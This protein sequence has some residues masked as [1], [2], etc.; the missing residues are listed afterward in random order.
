[1]PLPPGKPAPLLD[2][3]LLPKE[4]G[5]LF[6]GD[7]GKLLPPDEGEGPPTDEGKPLPDEGNVLPPASVVEPD[8]LPEETEGD[9]LKADVPEPGAL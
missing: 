4:E 3:E 7:V 6:A 9:E 8:P 1:M 2:E 5:K